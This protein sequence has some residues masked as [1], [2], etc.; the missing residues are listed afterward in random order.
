MGLEAE[1]DDRVPADPGSI[2]LSFQSIQLKFLKK[3]RK[4]KYSVAEKSPLG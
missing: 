3:H 1:V 2:C 4:D